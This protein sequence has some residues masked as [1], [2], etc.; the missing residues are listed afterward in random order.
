[1]TGMF[2]ALVIGAALL[3]LGGCTDFLG[4]DLSLKSDAMRNTMAQAVPG[5]PPGRSAQNSK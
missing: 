4:N 1:M 2:R 3:A 5:A